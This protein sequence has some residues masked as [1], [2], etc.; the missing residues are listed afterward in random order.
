MPPLASITKPSTFFK[1]KTEK[2]CQISERM[3]CMCEMVQETANTLNIYGSYKWILN[4]N[5]CLLSRFRLSKTLQA[6][7]TT[8]FLHS[9]T[10]AVVRARAQK[11]NNFTYDNA[12]FWIASDWTTSNNSEKW[13]ALGMPPSDGRKSTSVALLHCCTFQ[14]FGLLMDCRNLLKQFSVYFVLKADLNFSFQ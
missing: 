14:N 11:F 10:S 1:E 3:I 2:S 6:D 13:T 9:V 5:H 8:N 12:I 4:H 7:S